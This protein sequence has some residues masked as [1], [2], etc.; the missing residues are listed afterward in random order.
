MQSA[1]Q[2][3][4]TIHNYE[5]FINF[6][7]YFN[8]FQPDCVILETAEYATNVAYFSYDGLADKELNPVLDV[9]EHE[10]ELIPLEEMDYTL[11]ED[12]ELLT[13]G[14]A[15]ESEA[16]RGW[17]VSGERQFDISME[18]N[19]IECT[20]DKKYFAEDEARVYFQ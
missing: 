4:D 9:N 18:E 12:G 11:E 10:E 8:I 14:F 13:I 7:Y 20:I 16:S 19:G 15:D 5:K 3:Y 6:D 17:L 2:E 1:F